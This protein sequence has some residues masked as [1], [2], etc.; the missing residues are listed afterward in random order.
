MK[1]FVISLLTLTVFFLA[2]NAFAQD[3]GKPKLN[4]AESH[5]V[6]GEL[7]LAKAHVDGYFAEP[8]NE[9]KLTKGKTWLTRAKVYAALATTD[10]EEYQ[11]L[12][13]NPLEEVQ[14]SFD[15][16][17]ELEKETSLTYVTVFGPQEKYVTLTQDFQGTFMINDLFGQFY[18]LGAEAFDGDLADAVKYFEK[19]LVIKP[20][21]TFSIMNIISAAYNMDEP[22]EDAIEKYSRQLM[23]MK[24]RVDSTGYS[25]HNILSGFKFNKANNLMMEATNAS[26]SAQAAEV[27]EEALAVAEEGIEFFPE[28]EQLRNTA[29]NIYIKLDKTE[30]A[31]AEI[32]GM[33]AETPDKD[34]YFNL[35]ALY[36]RLGDIENAAANYQKAIDIDPDYYNAYYNLGAVYFTAGNKKYAQA[37]EY[38]DMN[39]EYM[40]GEDGEKGKALEAESKEL[41]A[42]AAPAFEK[43]IVIDGSERQ[44][45]EVLQ[46]IYYVLGN[47]EKVEELRKKLETMPETGDAGN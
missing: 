10:N 32:E 35:G 28:D 31:I 26:D 19:A 27:F 23:E 13:D 47:K 33:V 29:L 41:F 46:R 44:P 20:M 15:K 3:I 21:D 25:G 43:V 18:N 22:D 7:A 24:F 6:D 30:E 9:K 12:D 36:D 45:F 42:K 8:K 39:G 37:G 1:K 34:L 5:L 17:K 14:E 40:D 2:N 11:A 16:I 4:K 38:K